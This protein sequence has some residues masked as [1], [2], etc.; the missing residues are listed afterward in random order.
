MPSRRYIVHVDMDAFFAAVEQRDHPAW[1]GRPVVVGADPKGGRGRGVVAAASY[2]A[3]AFGIHS[4]MPIS[5]AYSLCPQAVFVRGDHEKYERES[6]RIFAVLE[7]FTPDIEPLSIDEAFLDI[8]RSFHLFGTAEE[9]CLKIKAEIKRETGLTASVGLA[10]NKFTA[11]IASDIGKPDGFVAVEP[12]K[13]LEFLHPLPVEKLWGVGPVM[14]RE[15][16]KAHIRT[17]GDLAHRSLEDMVKRFGAAGEHVWNLASG[18]DPREVSGG[19]EAKSVGAEHTF[20]EDTSDTDLLRGT[21]VALCERVSRRMRKEGISGRTVVLKIRFQ[22]FSTHTRSLTLPR[23]TNFSDE[24]YRAAA[25]SLRRFDT[26]KRKVRLLGVSVKNMGSP[27]PHPGLFED[28]SPADGKKE[29]LHSALDRIKDKFGER[30][31]RRR[32][33]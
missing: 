4:A 25:G 28:P 6:E 18:I 15:L 1:R 26:R 19:G 29:R 11:K 3:R 22:N 2:E 14:K 31:I 13:L 24:L 23:P 16:E 7:R 30:A 10:P 12:E 17:I 33:A 32:K 8:T 20:D 5:R 27:P 21:L 9:A